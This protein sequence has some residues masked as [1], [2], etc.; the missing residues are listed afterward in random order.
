MLGIS[1][2]H[3]LEL[4][5]ACHRVSCRSFIPAQYLHVRI[6]QQ[7]GC[8]GGRWALPRRDAT[9][10]VHRIV[11]GVL[12]A[13]QGKGAFD[14]DVSGNLAVL[15]TAHPLAG[16]KELSLQKLAEETFLGIFP[17]ESFTANNVTETMLHSFFQTAE[18]TLR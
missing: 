16:R 11:K 12:L 13:V 14:L 18:N 5:S 15:P 8:I 6:R 3:P 1:I 4:V 9:E 2:L 10:V 7:R 17:S